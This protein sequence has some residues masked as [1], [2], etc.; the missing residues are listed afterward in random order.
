MYTTILFFQT[1]CFNRTYTQVFKEKSL[2]V[3]LHPSFICSEGRYMLSAMVQVKKYLTK[4]RMC[5]CIFT[6]STFSIDSVKGNFRKG[7]WWTERH[8][9]TSEASLGTNEI[10]GLYTHSSKPL[11]KAQNSSVPRNS[12]D[13]FVLTKSNIL[14]SDKIPIQIL[15]PFLPQQ[16]IKQ[17]IFY[18][19]LYFSKM[20][21]VY[22]QFWK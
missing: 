19:D 18:L 3:D 14:V 22:I 17:K 11:T 5:F 9:E 10:Y 16:K 21:M 1:S 6:L 15:A 12:V 7:Y 4:L 13:I 2:S 20:Y 8:A